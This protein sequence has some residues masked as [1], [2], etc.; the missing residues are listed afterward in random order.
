MNTPSR[1]TKI[2]LNTIGVLTIAFLSIMTLLSAFIGLSAFIR[3]FTEDAGAIG[4]FGCLGGAAM[5]WMTGSIV[6][7]I[8]K[9]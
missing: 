8:L 4:V 1:P 6:R 2:L 9:S 5:A 7:D 3:I